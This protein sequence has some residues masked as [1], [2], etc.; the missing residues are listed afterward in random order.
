MKYTGERFIPSE[1]ISIMSLEHMHR[2]M[3]LAKFCAGKKVLD[4]ASGAGYGSY[5]LSQC[6]GTTVTGADISAEAVAYAAKTYQNDNLQFI[7]A[8]ITDLSALS[9]KSFDIVSC[10][11]T[12]EHISAE[13]QIV[14]LSEISRLL[15][16]DGI[17]FISTPSIASPLHIKDNKYH[18]SELSLPDFEQLLKLHFQNCR[19]YGQSV[20][21]CSCIGDEK[22]TEVLSLGAEQNISDNKYLIAVC[23]NRLLPELPGSVLIDKSNGAFKQLTKIRNCVGKII[24]VYNTM[25][26]IVALPFGR[27]KIKEKILRYKW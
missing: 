8:S 5:M 20:F 19:I 18:L 9:D 6:P 25:L 2:Y 22:N 27:S 10:F 14:A 7:N 24:P 16:E 21:C 26:D 3:F 1:K 23:S 4:V 11:E 15:K 12:I 13:N 17:L